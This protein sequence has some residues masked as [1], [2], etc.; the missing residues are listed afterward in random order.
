[1]KQL[2][3]MRRILYFLLSII[4]ANPLYAHEFEVDGIYY[5]IIS[6][7]DRTVEVTHKD[8]GTEQPYQ[9]GRQ[10]IYQGDISIPKTVVYNNIEFNVISIGDYS[11]YNS[12]GLNSVEI[13]N[14]IKIISES[15]FQSSTIKTLAIPSS[16]ERIDRNAFIWCNNL[17]EVEIPGN[18][19]VIGESAFRECSKLEKL[20]LDEGI[21]TLGHQFISGSPIKSL[22]IPRS[23]RYIDSAPFHHC[24]LLQI[25]LLKS[26][27]I[28]SY[29][30]QY[31]YNV[32][33]G[34]ETSP[35]VFV[36][37]GSSSSFNVKIWSTNIKEYDQSI[38][39]E[40][41]K[42]LEKASFIRVQNGIKYR[43]TSLLS[44]FEM[45]VIG[46]LD[47]CNKVTISESVSWI[48]KVF[49]PK[50]IKNNSFKNRS[51]IE[52]VIIPNN[53]TTIEEEAFYG[54]QNIQAVFSKIAHPF[55]ISTNVFDGVVRAFGKLIVPAGTKEE[56][57]AEGWKDF[58][59]IEE[60]DNFDDDT[61]EDSQSSKC[62]TPSISYSGGK[63]V[64]SCET[65]GAE[66]HSTI[67]DTDIKSY[68]GNEILLTATYHITVYATKTGYDNSDVATATLCWIDKEPVIDVTGVSQVP[69]QAV[70]IQSEG[71]L[72]TVQGLDDGTEVSVYGVNGTE[73]GAAISRKGQAQV[74]TNLSAGSV[75]IV[76]IGECSVK[77]VI[78]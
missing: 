17:V 50:T 54:S 38:T 68:S 20:I 74:N 72:L 67:T 18:V 44:D 3:Y 76:K 32:F 33:D 47:D 2:I 34:C 28:H 22:V 8:F 16:V 64:F 26:A 52:K 29:G 66:Y 6:A 1:M 53:I 25:V 75:A 14:S 71:G 5:N 46:C 45:N 49:V 19:K 36:P 65:E 27:T 35:I 13:P 69:A 41:I 37:Q 58:A 60:R 39:D 63:I 78:K 59:T 9:A 40:H 48:D 70:L 56:V 43:V 42:E 4:A 73:A 51:I 10:Y 55:D 23:V 11:F 21:D 77:V 61:P 15:A 31:Q 7:V 62:S 57:V 30:E 24:S 12:V